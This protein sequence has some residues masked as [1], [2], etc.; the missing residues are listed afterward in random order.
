MERPSFQI[1]SSSPVCQCWPLL[2]GSARC[3]TG[4]RTQPLSSHLLGCDQTHGKLQRSLPTRGKI[5]GDERDT[6]DTRAPTEMERTASPSRADLVSESPQT[7]SFSPPAWLCSLTA[8]F[9]A[10]SLVTYCVFYHIIT[11]NDIA[12]NLF[13][14]PKNSLRTKF[15]FSG[16][17]C[18]EGFFFFGSI[19]TH[20][21]RCWQFQF[22]NSGPCSPDLCKMTLVTLDQQ[23]DQI[24]SA[25][26]CPTS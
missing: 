15:T 10:F 19:N 3:Q 8:H 25:C 18:T 23:S 12:I 21:G 2:L 6:R 24:E 7:L 5:T 13:F 17:I 14:K 4:L 22:C 20:S 16:I 9:H 11:N 1:L 26:I